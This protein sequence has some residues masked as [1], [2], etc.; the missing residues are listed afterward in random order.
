MTSSGLKRRL[1]DADFLWLAAG[2]L[3]GE[4]LVLTVAHGPSLLR[5]GGLVFTV[6]LA[7]FLLHRSRI[8]WLLAAFA[9]TVQLVSEFAGQPIGWLLFSSGVVLIC[10]LAPRSIRAVWVRQKAVA[11]RQRLTIMEKEL[12]SA[13]YSGIRWLWKLMIHG[14]RGYE[15]LRVLAGGAGRL[16]GVVLIGVLLLA[17]AMGLLYRFHV[18]SGNGNLAIDIL[19]FLAWS[20]YTLMRLLLVGL[21]IA[22]L[23]R[24]LARSRVSRTQGGAVR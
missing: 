24:W 7:Y 3:V 20:G 18:G 10:L 11:I 9:A 8:A 2:V 22:A 1:H 13:E 6:A 16:I 23:H 19:W 4:W 21:L 5:A 12:E 15:R 17:P 14:A